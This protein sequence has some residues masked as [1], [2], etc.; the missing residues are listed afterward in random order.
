MSLYSKSNYKS[1]GNMVHKMYLTGK[2]LD[3]CTLDRRSVTK[4]YKAIKTKCQDNKSIFENV[5][6]SLTEGFLKKKYKSLVN[7]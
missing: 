3:P 1:G 7:I 6:R 4:L 5:L 2:I